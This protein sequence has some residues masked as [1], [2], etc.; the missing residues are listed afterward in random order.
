VIRNVLDNAVK[1]TEQGQVIIEC[2]QKANSCELFIRDSGIGIPQ[3]QIDLVFDEFHQLDNPERDRAKGL[4]LGLAIVKRLCDLSSIG[5]QLKSQP[6]KG[7]TVTLTLAAGIEA[8]IMQNSNDQPIDFSDQLI[9]II[10]DEQDI[11]QAMQ[12]VLTA[13]HAEVIVAESLDKAMQQLGQV[14]MSPSIIISD[15][16][17]RGNATG[18]QAIDAIREEY[19]RDIPAII[20]TGDTAV[21]KLSEMRDVAD[22]VLYKPVDIRE[23]HESIASLVGQKER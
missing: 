15:F 8:A 4:G 11:R 2:E 22:C 14:S 9:V 16:R 5:L 7:S 3:S 1:Y 20:I 13:H 23:L 17:L 18:V 6:G 12:L 21:E 19:N 10:D